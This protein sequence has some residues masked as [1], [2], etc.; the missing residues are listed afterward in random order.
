LGKARGGGVLDGRFAC[1]EFAHGRSIVL[2]TLF[3]H[4]D[5]DPNDIKLV[6]LAFV[7]MPKLRLRSVRDGQEAIDYLDGD[8]QY[9]DRETFPLPDVII[10]DLR[11]PRVTGFEFLT[12]LHSESSG[13]LKLIPVMVFSTSAL[14]ADVDRAYALHANCY[15]TKPVDFQL[16]GER[17]KL[18]TTFWSEHVE[19]PNGHHR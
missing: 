4:V 17:I 5:D 15:L 6:E 9:K 7:K 8:G 16:F 14:E 19:K 11:M 2:N 1:A 12:W 10:L 18:M 13:N 3:L